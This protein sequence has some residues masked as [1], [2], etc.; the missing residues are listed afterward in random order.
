[1][2]RNL[3]RNPLRDLF[4]SPFLAAALLLPAILFPYTLHATQSAAP[5]AGGR[6]E[7]PPPCSDQDAS[8]S[9]CGVSSADHK[10]ADSLYRESVKLAR[11][12]H[13]EQALEKLQAALAISPRDTVYATAAQALRQK[14]AAMYLHQ[15]DEAIEKGD[16]A[17][18]LAAFRRAQ[19]LDPANDYA[20]QRLRDV[21][22]APPPALAAELPAADSGEVRLEP[23]AG[24]HNFEF[25]GTSTAAFEKF[26]ALFGITTIPDDGLNARNVRIT[27]DNVDWETGSQLLEKTSKILLIPLSEHQVLLANDT[28]EN[29]N[30]L[31]E[32]SL[33]TFYGQGGSTPQ[34]LT[35]LI[36]ALRVLFDLRFVTADPDQGA[37]VVRAPAPTLDA[38]ARFLDDLQDDQPTVM[39]EI[40]VFEV[41]TILSKDVGVSTP[42][43]FTVFN[44][45]SEINRLTSGSSFQQILAA[46]QASGQAVNAS[47]I[48]A[49]L[50]ATG[51]SSPLSQPFATF[52][53]GLT[54]SAVTVAATNTHLNGSDSLARTVDEL[55]LR[56]EHGNA[57]TMKVGERYPIVTTE[58][59]ATTAT[60]SLLSS[61]GINVP[62]STSATSI[63]TPQFS[64]EDLGLVL[65]TT[66]QVHGKLIS[67]DYELTLR[68]LGPT[69]AEGPPVLN[70]RETKGSISTEDGKGVVI[71]GI[72]DKGETSAINGIPLL[73]A[74]PILGKAFSV[75]T[76]EKTS[77]ELLIVV[78]PHVTSANRTR[79]LYLPVPMNVPK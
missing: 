53:G 73:S 79:G 42:D 70:N 19:E 32:M 9:P 76:R 57:A 28:V 36:A 61:L 27:L 47:S 48:L 66:P 14:V 71:A 13:F 29:R 64:Y 56:S 37:I 69:Q 59:S 30:S 68:S 54:L 10:K 8:L 25:R 21:L 18:A 5:A 2:P 6:V 11:H 15:G 38:V 39:L 22:P 75:A 17:S 52:G 26:A 78:T 24:A 12:G 51:S 65:K 74:V 40:Q 67:L 4:R 7:N 46:L 35:D 72:V 3:L 33:R 31:T 50:L 41:S 43:Q 60:S 16:A 77:D 1:M 34:Q 62:G 63:P 55:L 58:F 20:A 44:I 45:P 23:T 49:A